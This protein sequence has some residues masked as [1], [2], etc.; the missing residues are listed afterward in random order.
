MNSAATSL[1][2]RLAEA[3]EVSPTLEAFARSLRPVADAVAEAPGWRS[4][5]RGE[6]VGH[7]LHPTMTDLPLGLW[8]SSTVLDL[9]G[10]DDGRSADRLLGLGI[11][12]AAPTALTGLAD[13]RR[14]GDRVRRVGVLHAALNT[15]ALALY[16]ASWVLRRQGHRGAG[17]ATSLAAG[18]VAGV[19]GYLGGHMTLVLDSPHEST[20]ADTDLP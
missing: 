19:S 1:P 10:T 3:A 14:G 16:S 9:V 20:D 5:L 11:L 7:A 13:W 8:I 17:V 4:L 6:P 12:S 15:G 18:A 2:R